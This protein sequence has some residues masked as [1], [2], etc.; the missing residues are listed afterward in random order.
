MLLIAASRTT[1]P[2][3]FRLAPPLA[4]Y[5]ESWRAWLASKNRRPRGIAKYA[6]TLAQFL[7]FLGSTPTVADLHRPAVVTYAATRAALGR[8]GSTLINDLAVIRKFALYLIELGVLAVDPTAGIERPTKALPLPRPLSETTLRA[9]MARIAETPPDLSPLRQRCWGR[10]RLGVALMLYGGL[11]IAEAAALHRGRD[12]QL[13]EQVLVVPAGAAKGGQARRVPIVPQLERHL[14]GVA[15]AERAP[16]LPVLP[17][18]IG[19][20]TGQALSHRSLEHV[21]DRWLRGLGFDLHCHQLRHSFAS[22][23]LWRGADLRG[24]QELLGHKSIATTERYLLVDDQHKLRAA[25][26]L[27][28]FG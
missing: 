14:A 16:G 9:L 19:P 11:R 10:N 12:V 28:D 5:T 6:R 22:H 27:P 25:G 23:M 4:D 2:A 26:R 3:P 21:A 8:A 15:E 20:R 17:V 1:P 18:L 7:A 13:A 24:I